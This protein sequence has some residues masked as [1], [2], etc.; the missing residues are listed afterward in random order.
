[1]TS[2]EQAAA[3]QA[4]A[5]AAAKAEEARRLAEDH[6]RR[7]GQAVYGIGGRS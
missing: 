3:A 7:H 2:Q 4:A 5:E 1:M 6:L